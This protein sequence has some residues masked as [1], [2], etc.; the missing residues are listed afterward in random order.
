MKVLLYTPRVTKN[1]SQTFFSDSIIIDLNQNI[2]WKYYF[3]ME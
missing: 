2:Y 3:K 1:K